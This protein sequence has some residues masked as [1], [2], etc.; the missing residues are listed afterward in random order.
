MNPD[1][2]FLTAALSVVAGI[3][4]AAACG[5]RVFVPLLV[6]SAATRA[7]L[8]SVSEGFAWIGS[9]PA[10]VCFALASALEIAA[11]YVPW[12][13]NALDAIAT[14]TA[15]VAG[16]VISAAVIVELEPWLRWTLAAIAGGGAAAAV[17]IPSVIA[18]GASTATTGGTGNHLVATTEAAAAAGF[19][20]SSLLA[21]ALPFLVPVVVLVLV[22]IAYRCIR[23]REGSP[24]AA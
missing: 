14:P 11:Y 7:G 4:L 18:R 20:L 21:L 9:T 16:I 10:V 5:F 8:M 24:S 19:S 15:V 2:T 12:V 23:A 6:V 17:Q 13:D 3:G 1:T 22:W